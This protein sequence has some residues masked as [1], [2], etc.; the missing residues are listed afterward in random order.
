MDHPDTH[1][2]QQHRRLMR[3]S[4][5][6]LL[7]YALLR[8][9]T[10]LLRVLP[11]RVALFLGWLNAWFF[12]YVIRFRVDEAKRRIRLVL[13]EGVSETQATRI[14]WQSWKNIVFSGVE[15]TRIDLM[16]RDWIESV[17]D[18]EKLFSTLKAQTDTGKG[19]ISAVAHMGSWE[20]AGVYG[21]HIGIPVFTFVAEQKNPL[22]NTYLNRMRQRPGI[23]VI[24]R[25]TDAIRDII[26]RLRK[27][28]L[29]AILPDVRMRRG[30]IM[31]PFLGGEANVGEGMAMFAR[32]CDVPIFPCIVTRHGWAQHKGKVGPAI[33]PD[34]R[35]DKESDILRMTKEVL[36]LIDEEIRKDPGQWFWFNKR[37]ILDP[38]E[39]SS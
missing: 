24:S 37:W 38:V 1:D 17:L 35:L 29:L 25:G 10:A 36:S 20:L 12:F 13:G 30:G 34:S 23:P 15:M 26:R 9:L 14:A 2:L 31:V 5:K 27:G 32:Q 28:Y 39:P 19:A 21:H 7:E 16:T 4:P 6:H 33:W 18:A 22:V 11:Y 8:M 3:Y